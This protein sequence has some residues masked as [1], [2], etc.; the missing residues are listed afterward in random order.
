MSPRTV[1]VGARLGLFLGLSMLAGVLVAALV[2]PA[3]GLVGLTAQRGAQ[4]FEA[5]PAALQ[6]PT[7]KQRTRIEAADGT[8]IARFYSEN[9]VYVGI[10]KIAP[11]M[12]QAI[13]AIE[14]TRFYEH[15]GFDLRGT[16]RALV[17]N[18]QAGTVTQGGSTLTQQYVKNVL[19][20]TARTKSER[21][22][23]AED[24]VARKLQ[25]ARYALALEQRWSKEQI[26][27]GYLNIA[28]F[29]AGT[30]GVE[31]AAQRYFSKSAKKL[32]L[33]EAAT[34]AGI[35]KYPTLYDPL[36]NPA[37]SRARRDLV[38]RRMV[39]LGMATDADARA[40]AAVPMRKS[41]DPTEVPNRCLTS[42]APFFCDYVYATFLDDP[43][44]GKT[45][46]DRRQLFNGGG[47]TIR[48]TLDM[49]AQRAA[50]KAVNSFI[51]P[52]D[53]SERMAAIAMVEPGTGNI[54]AMAQNRRY[55]EGPG[56]TYVNNVVDAKYNGTTG[57]QAGSTFKIFTLAAAIEKGI[58]IG[59]P[60][61][62]PVSTVI[63]GG[64]FTN[65]EGAPLGDPWPVRNSTTSYDATFDMRSGAA[66]SVNTFFAELERRVGLCD[67]IDAASR[68]GIHDA[69][70]RDPVR[71]TALQV[72]PFT[73][74]VTEVAPLTLAN[75]YATFAARG[76]HCEP[77]AIKAVRSSSG[78]TLETAPPLCN[79]AFEPAVADAVNEILSE[80]IDGPNP[81]RTGAA[82]S[83]GRPAAGKTG[84]TSFNTAVWFAGYTPD[85]AAAVWA[86]HPDAPADFPMEDVTINGRYYPTVYG[87]LLPGPIWRQ[88]MLGALAG[89][90]ASSFV[91]I[92]PSQLAGEQGI[93]PAVSGLTPAAAVKQLSRAGFVPVVA[94][95]AV[96][97]TQAKGYVAYTDPTGGSRGITGTTVTIYV[98]SGIPPAPAPEPTKT[99]K[100]KPTPTPTATGGGNPGQGGG[101][102]GGGGGGGG[103]GNPGGGGG[104]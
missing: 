25:E 93:V 20:A 8:L 52:K 76:R 18:S 102:P 41:L 6:T 92:D 19:Q 74:G 57:Q 73:L 64:S 36:Q 71:R 32:S 14:D 3:V 72:A 60:I 40:A 85:L 69:L 2:M 38:L 77:R 44:Y 58:P 78:D 28:Y 75:A 48:T 97:S 24:T 54:L 66:L 43:A 15:N 30:Y 68:A 31:A 26:L 47:L 17:A 53:P 83:L 98:S 34:L 7:L 65:C 45:R 59:T 23:A 29:G 10:K 39:D 89:T 13:V 101:N 82:M 55:G 80:V 5:L 22:A 50:Q 12:Q 37:E 1:G 61:Q 21:A 33:G 11:V 16:M 99:K 103:G 100:P 56:R 81:N 86:G 87:S 42:V 67:T 9:R 46:A 70:G 51:P 49:T 63:P 104:G 94:S 88:A 27:E 95:D 96:E 90:S 4:T 62:S 79:Q 84:T 35:V 91:A